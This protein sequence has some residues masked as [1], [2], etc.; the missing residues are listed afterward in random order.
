MS[1][2]AIRK[3]DRL[4]SRYGGRLPDAV[5]I[6][7]SRIAPDCFGDMVEQVR[8]RYNP[9]GRDPCPDWHYCTGAARAFIIVRPTP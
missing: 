4:Q 6:E 8:Y 7:D 9:S 5:A 3:G 1:G 2:P